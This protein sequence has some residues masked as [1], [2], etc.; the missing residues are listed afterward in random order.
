[1]ELG[2][3][4]PSLFIRSTMAKLREVGLQP[5]DEILKHKLIKVMPTEPRISLTASQ[6]LPLDSFCD[7]A[8]NLFELL[9]RSS[10][11]SVEPRAQKHIRPD[12]GYNSST[13][14]NHRTQSS[15]VSSACQPFH[16]DQRPK[17]CRSH[18]YAE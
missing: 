9:N 14:S 6:S 13:N 18:V 1:M 8:D 16:S 3:R 4:R 11:C 2:G 15:V 10:L 5:S 17:L 12:R 7:V